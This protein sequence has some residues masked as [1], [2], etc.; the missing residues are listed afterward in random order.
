MN[1]LIKLFDFYLNQ[2]IKSDYNCIKPIF[3]V[4]FPLNAYKL[5][6]KRKNNFKDYLLFNSKFTLIH[7]KI[8]EIIKYE[9]N[10][11]FNS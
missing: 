4:N 5:Y 8:N 2:I 11:V 10:S 6:L 1:C 7:N 9:V 3:L